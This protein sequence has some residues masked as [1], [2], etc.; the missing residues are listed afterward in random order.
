MTFTRRL[1]ILVF[2]NVLALI[3][4]VF[5]TGILPRPPDRTAAPIRLVA[6]RG[7]VA[8]FPE[9]TTEGILAAASVGADAVEFD[10]WKSADGTWWVMHDEDVSVT[11]DGVGNLP[12][13]S[14]TKLASLTIVGGVGFQYPRDAGRHTVPRLTDV[15]TAL[16]EMTTTIYV[17]CKPRDE[18][19]AADLARLLVATGVADRSALIVPTVEQARRVKAVDR[20]IR[21]IVIHEYFDPPDAD[22]DIDAW[23]TDSFHVS[24]PQ[25][26]SARLYEVETY[27][28][29]RIPQTDELATLERMYRWN[30]AA[31]ITNN[32]GAATARIRELQGS[33]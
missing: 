10:G 13:L 27:A 12:A 6:H 21:T 17:H 16:A 8:N 31:F 14:D 3:L 15:V 24:D 23:L 29:L 4:L 30:A 1:S 33:P 19:A 11:T 20:R 32:L 18:S 22:L 26:I 7:D 2:L 5:A 25:F 9:N 28:N